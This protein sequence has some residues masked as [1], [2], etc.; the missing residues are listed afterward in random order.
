LLFL[1][2]FNDTMSAAW[3]MLHWKLRWL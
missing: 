3:V 2:L 1:A